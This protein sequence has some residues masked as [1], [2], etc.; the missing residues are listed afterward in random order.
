MSPIEWISFFVSRVLGVSNFRFQNNQM[1]TII[2][3]PR[4][5]VIFSDDD[6]DVQSPPQNSI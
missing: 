6:W 3:Y 4:H 5:P 2:L 1:Y